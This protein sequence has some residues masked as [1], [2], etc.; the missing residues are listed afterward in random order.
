MASARR[1]ASRHD[2][3][4]MCA[5]PRPACPALRDP[6][7]EPLSQSA[8]MGHVRRRVGLA[9]AALYAEDGVGERLALALRPWRLACAS[10]IRQL[11]PVETPRCALQ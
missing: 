5:A 2:M 3:F 1:P 7:H 4:R 6:V 9:S 11:R 10:L 8:H